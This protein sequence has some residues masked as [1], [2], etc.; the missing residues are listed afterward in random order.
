MTTA[1]LTTQSAGEGSVSVKGQTNSLKPGF[2]SV[3]GYK[4]ALKFSEA[5]ASST[6]VP[7]AYRANQANCMIAISMAS[8][9]NADPLVVMQN[10]NI[11]QGKPSFSAQFLIASW[12]VCGRFSPIR[13][14]WTE[15]RDG[16]RAVSKDLETGELL[17]GT[18]ITM[19][20]ARAEGWSTK[21]GSKWATMPEQMLMYRSGAFLIR[22]YAAE[23]ALGMLTTEEVEDITGLKCIDATSEDVKR[24]EVPAM[25]TGV[26]VVESSPESGEV[27]PSYKSAIDATGVKAARAIESV[28][29][30]QQQ[31]PSSPAEKVEAAAELVTPVAATT[32]VETTDT[33][34]TTT[35]SNL[36]TNG[37]GPVC[38][39]TLAYLGELVKEI[40]PP[41][42]IWVGTLQKRF[43][44]TSAK[45]LNENQA[46]SIVKWARSKVESIRLTKWSAGE[47]E[48]REASQEAAPFQTT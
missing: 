1:A 5:F 12:N 41:K 18:M 48:K 14:K 26:Q 21:P 23:I 17:I 31:T 10:L 37:E 22:A 42:D 7:M 25:Q 16:C 4:L 39:E 32:A 8:R 24:I 44:V 20:M 35:A 2:Q 29:V 47:G 40:N 46:Q 28:V 11:I 38:K 27:A 36:D 6:L 9:M 3:E 43:G 34:S 30:E 19:E 33:T 15:K 13:Y 45:E